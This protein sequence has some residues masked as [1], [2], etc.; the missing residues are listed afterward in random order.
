MCRGCHHPDCCCDSGIVGTLG[1]MWVFFM[2]VMGCG[3]PVIGYALASVAT[4]LERIWDQT[5]GG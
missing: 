5:V 2:L 3:V 1:G 4:V